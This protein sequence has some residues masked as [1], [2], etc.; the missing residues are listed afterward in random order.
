MNCADS[1]QP[2]VRVV[3]TYLGSL[4]RPVPAK[5]AAGRYYLVNNYNPGFFGDGSNA[6]TDSNLNNTIYTIPPSSVETIGD[7][8]SAKNISWAYYG[9]H[10][11]RRNRPKKYSSR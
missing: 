5:C 7:K 9:D 1:T 11:D 3:L 8:L 4:A 6:Y 2:G 10:F